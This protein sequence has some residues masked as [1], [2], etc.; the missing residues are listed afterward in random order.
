[1]TYRG[2]AMH[3]LADATGQPRSGP[4]HGLVAENLTA[5][6]RFRAPAPMAGSRPADPLAA[7]LED[8]VRLDA[9]GLSPTHPCSVTRLPALERVDLSGNGVAD[10]RPPSGRYARERLNL[11]TNAVTD[12]Q[13]LA[14]RPNLKVLPLNGNA[15]SDIGTPTHRTALE[16]LGPAGNP[17]GDPTALQ[18]LLHLRR[19]D[20]TRTRRLTRPRPPTLARGR[21]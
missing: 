17:V 12:V 10:L 18:D 8:A 2:S 15:A 6:G 21:G 9:S 20:L 5:T 7:A 4:R 1:M 16:N 19:P 14:G 13:A 11:S 3:P